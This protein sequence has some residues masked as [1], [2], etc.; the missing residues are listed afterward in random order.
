MLSLSQMVIVVDIRWKELVQRM[1]LVSENFA[2]QP[3][4]LL[5]D[6]GFEVR[7]WLAVAILYASFD[8][9]VEAGEFFIAGVSAPGWDG[10][11]Q[12]AED[13]S[14]IALVQASICHSATF[15]DL[16]R[17]YCTIAFS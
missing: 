16:Q 9:F 1:L 12:T 3:S 14:F 5:F 4:F 6:A 15:E 13:E 10:V 17:V 7:I 8:I 2:E 11:Q